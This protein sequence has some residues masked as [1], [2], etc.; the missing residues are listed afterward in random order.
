MA[1]PHQIIETRYSNEEGKQRY[2]RQLFNQGAPHYDRIGWIGSLGT[3]HIY[4]K[5]ALRRAGLTPGM[6]VL[7]VACG[8]GAV[9]RAILQVLNGSGSVVGVDPS[10]GMLAQAR[11]N[12]ATEFREGVAEALPFPD[13][14]FD[15]LTM[16]Y[17]L[18]HVGDL[19]KAF[20]EYRRVLRPG[21]RVLLLEITRPKGGFSLA[22]TR[23][24]FRDFLG[25]MMRLTGGDKTSREMM[26][27]Y[28]ET[29]DVCV[30]PENILSALQE[31]GFSEVNRHVDLG[32]FSEYRGLNPPRQRS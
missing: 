24:Y 29:I 11:A 30:P 13:D 12:V 4:R 1:Q 21:G 26:T 8:T 19:H 10:A 7:D 5:R 27:Y 22:L 17:A 20:A 2:L 9:T 3:G 23:F 31:S 18:R 16:G 6:S 14:S 32:L 25:W 15:F 28:W